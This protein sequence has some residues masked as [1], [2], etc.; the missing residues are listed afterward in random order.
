MASKLRVIKQGRLTPLKDIPIKFPKFEK[1][2]LNYLEVP[3]KLKAGLPLIPRIA[4]K[5][6]FELQSSDDKTDGKVEPEKKTYSENIKPQEK[7]S[8]RK[9]KK[10]IIDQIDK[11]II[12]RKSKGHEELEIEIKKNPKI[13]KKEIIIESEEEIDSD[14]IDE[15]EEQDENDDEATDNTLDLEDSD[16]SFSERES[17]KFEEPKKD[18]ND[19][20]AGLTPEEREIKEKEEFL[21][22]F[23]ILKKSYNTNP[24]ISIPE[25]NEF[26][27]LHT[28][29]TSYE[30][31]IREIY[32]DDAV[33]S[34]RGYLFGTWILMEYV[35]VK[36]I[37]I[38]I[39]GFTV[40][41]LKNMY[42][43]DRM[44]IEL[45]E[46]SYSRWALNI[47]VELRLI[48]TIVFQAGIFYVGKIVA[49]NY[50]KGFGD[51]IANFGSHNSYSER[52]EE[53]KQAP[54]GTKMRGPRIN[55]DDI[56]A[57]HR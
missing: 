48:M 26:S 25:Y 47:P 54:E 12:K 34:Y 18:E 27:D 45:G 51:F 57:N 19:P 15:L 4:P 7:Q 20:Y 1:L 36:L 13:K 17:K 44:L 23:R 55:V 5:A 21:W 6:N 52:K 39:K 53:P 46:K 41:Q 29:K 3:E 32:L 16:E 8:S 22:R 2:Y 9:D 35:C 56:K 49:E 40:H 24:D 42:K 31:T 37:G 33:E 50:G 30:R 43:Y 28:M 38:D 10:S 11:N 14:L